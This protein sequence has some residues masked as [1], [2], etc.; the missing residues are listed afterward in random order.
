[1][2][3]PSYQTFVLGLLCCV[4]PALSQTTYTIQTVAGSSLVG[5]GV[6][7]L[8]AQLSAAEAL[9]LD[10][11][12]NVY[13]ADPSNH[14]VRKVNAAGM[15]QTVAGSGSPD[16][17]GAVGPASS[18]RLNAPYRVAADRAGNLYIADLGNN[19]VRKVGPD[20]V[21][22]TIAGTGQAGSAGDG[23]PAVSAQ[24]N[25]PRNVAVDGFGGLYIAE[26][27]GHRIRLVTPDGLIQ[28][29]A[30]T[31]L[32]GSAGEGVAAT[33]AQ[34]SY[35]AGISV[36]FTGTL[37]IADSGNQ[38]IR[39]VFAA[40]MT[41]VLLPTLSTPT[42]VIGDGS[43]GIYIADSGNLRILRRT[44][45]NVVFTV[46]SALS[47]PRDVAVDPLGNLFVADGRRVRL[48]SAIGLST[49]FAGDGTFG[50]GGDGGPALAA[51]L[52][53]PRRVTVGPPGTLYIAHA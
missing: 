22:T 8:N 17:S 37:Y 26:F 39:K 32:S 13:I 44:A 6:S 20:G 18:A 3:S 50:Y 35:P 2:P 4:A 10:S 31:G 29:V 40:Q 7:A 30:G 48:L 46:A 14:R 49:T 47:S 43:G 16:F 28:T 23:G 15:I 1:M 19:R 9:A 12:G 41:T 25:A 33:S 24:L 36:D 27:N 11:Q 38:R 42:G 45:G 21:I 52:S 34:L 51:L 5:D 53:R